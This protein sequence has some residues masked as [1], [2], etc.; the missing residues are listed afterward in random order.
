MTKQVQKTLSGPMSLSYELQTEVNGLGET[1]TIVQLNNNGGLADERGWLAHRHNA[2]QKWKYVALPEL[3]AIF[4][5]ASAAFEAV[6]GYSRE[7][8]LTRLKN[9]TTSYRHQGKLVVNERAE[10]VEH[11]VNPMSGDWRKVPI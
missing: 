11:I 1:T 2:V 3:A 8:Q 6:V 7:L 5:T 4:T 9:E 10:N